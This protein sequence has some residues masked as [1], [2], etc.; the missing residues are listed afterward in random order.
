MLPS[1]TVKLGE[2]A[3]EPSDIVIVMPAV[4]PAVISSVSNVS[5]GSGCD[6]TIT[7]IT[8]LTPVALSVTV[9]IVLLSSVTPVI[10]TLP[11]STSAT[12]ELVSADITVKPS[13]FA[14]SSVMLSSGLR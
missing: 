6:V 7:G 11:P 8:R 9:T 5:T 10:F 2:L 12:A 4:S 13:E 3:A 14:T 1:V